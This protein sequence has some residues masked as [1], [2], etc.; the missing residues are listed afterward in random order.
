MSDRCFFIPCEVSADAR[1]QRRN[2]NLL[3]DSLARS[4]R[5]TVPSN[6]P[7]TRTMAARGLL[8]LHP[9]T[10]PGIH[11][12]GCRCCFRGLIASL[13]LSCPRLSVCYLLLACTGGLLPNVATHAHCLGHRTQRKSAL[14]GVIASTMACAASSKYLDSAASTAM[15][16]RFVT[17][18]A[19]GLDRQELFAHL[20]VH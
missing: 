3:P 18:P 4:I 6:P 7:G 8:L 5:G 10:A 14:Q 19:I 13:D 1:H 2:S 20:G 16:L 11:A 17:M 12:A 9:T 15:D